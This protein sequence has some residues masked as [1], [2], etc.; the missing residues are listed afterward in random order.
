MFP[1]PTNEINIFYRNSFQHS[2]YNCHCSTDATVTAVANTKT[3]AVTATNAS[4]STTA[5]TAT[6]ASTSTTA[7]MQHISEPTS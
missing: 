3:T 2:N 1:K 6:N 4:T 7:A 5:V